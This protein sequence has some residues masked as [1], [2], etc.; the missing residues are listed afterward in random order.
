MI[1]FPSV[2]VIKHFVAAIYK[3]L[4]KARV[5]VPGKLFQLSLTNTLTDYKKIR[6]LQ[7]KKFYNNGPWSFS[8]FRA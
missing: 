3:F 7:T 1:S 2:N 8:T 4:Q 6:K 5:F